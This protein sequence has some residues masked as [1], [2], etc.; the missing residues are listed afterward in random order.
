MHE[1]PD[2]IA[3]LQELLDRSY[4]RAGSHLRSIITP[5]RRLSAEQVVAYLQGTKHVAMATVTADGRPRV[6]PVDAV[7]LNARFTCGTAASSMRV[8]HLRRNPAVSVTHMVG[9]EVAI[10]VHGTARLLEPGTE[11]AVA[12]AADWAEVY[13][14][15]PTAGARAW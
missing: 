10:T 4:E 3:A 13:G 14:S 5:E 7:F 15:D 1:S 9:D 11:E 6:G 12:V 8:R 2:E